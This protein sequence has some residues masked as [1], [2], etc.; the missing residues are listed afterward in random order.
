MKRLWHWATVP[1]MGH[2]EVWAIL[3]ISVQIDR[4]IR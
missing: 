4:L 2:L 3:V 1:R